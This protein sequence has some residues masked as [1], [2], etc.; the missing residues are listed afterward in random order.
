M[1]DALLNVISSA[2]VRVG[3][4]QGA[5]SKS[6]VRVIA[7]EAVADAVDALCTEFLIGLVGR[8][9]GEEGP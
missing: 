2:R 3:V 1:C 4:R 8:Q 7:S 6:A 9:K 5:L